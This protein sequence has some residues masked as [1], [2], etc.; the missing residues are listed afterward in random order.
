M[1][2]LY[3]LL[4]LLVIFAACC[5]NDALAESSIRNPL[6]TRSGQGLAAEGRRSLTE[7]MKVL[8]VVDEARAFT[9]N[10]SRTEWFKNLRFVARIKEMLK[11]RKVRL[12]QADLAKRLRIQ[13]VEIDSTI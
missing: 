3:P 2:F 10:L 13:K 1:R 4:S 12:E 7:E 5:S 8:D 6:L 9:L 11:K